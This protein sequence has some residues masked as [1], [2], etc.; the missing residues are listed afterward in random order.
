MLFWNPTA[1]SLYYKVRG[2]E[3]ETAVLLTMEIWPKI[4]CKST[5]K[6]EFP[7]PHKNS[8]FLGQR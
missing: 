4:H 7:Q 5:E 2:K 1:A 6:G 3:E 8:G